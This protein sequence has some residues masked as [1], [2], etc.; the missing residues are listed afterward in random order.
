MKKILLVALAVILCLA[1]VGCGAPQEPAAQASAGASEKS[2]EET[3]EASNGGTDAAQLTI[4]VAHC[5]LGEDYWKRTLWACKK[6]RM[7][8]ESR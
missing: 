7:N 8:W 1:F 5:V 6:R 2:P 4:G 3:A